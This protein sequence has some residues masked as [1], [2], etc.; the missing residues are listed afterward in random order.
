MTVNVGSTTLMD[1]L[2]RT[3]H[4]RAVDYVSSSLVLLYDCTCRNICRNEND[5]GE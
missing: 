3:I 5:S 4:Q 2:V 1:K